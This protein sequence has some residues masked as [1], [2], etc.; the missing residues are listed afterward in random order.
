NP[1][2]DVDK[3]TVYIDNS[4]GGYNPATEDL[5]YI[6]YYTD[7]TVSAI[8]DVTAGMLH[9]AP[10]HDPLIPDVAEGGKYFEI[11]GGTKQIEAVQLTMGVGTVKIPVIQF[12]IEQESN[13]APLDMTFTANLIDGDNDS[14][15][16]TFSVH[17][18]V[19]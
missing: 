13:P 3:V 19:A 6:V 7:G 1:E 10:R 17:V 12:T 4:V 5:Y 18:D 9:N 8:T 15:P 14:S 16:D 2:E 11:D